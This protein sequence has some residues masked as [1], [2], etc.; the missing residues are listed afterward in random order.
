MSPREGS[1]VKVPDLCSFPSSTFQ[2]NYRVTLTVATGGDGVAVTM[3]PFIG[4]TDG[5]T[6]YPIH[7][8]TNST[9]GGA[10]TYGNKNWAARATIQSLYDEI[11]PVSGELTIK[12]TGVTTS[13]SGV[14][15]AGILDR[16]ETSPTGRVPDYATAEGLA[17]TETCMIKSGGC[18]V[19]WRPQDNH[20]LEYQQSVYV[21]GADPDIIPPALYIVTSGMTVGTTVL[22]ECF[23]NWEGIPVL[24]TVD[25]VGPTPSTA[26]TSWLD[27]AFN[28]AASMRSFVSPLVER[29]PQIAS[30]YASRQVEN[31]LYARNNRRGTMRIEL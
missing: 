20:D 23:V 22:V 29:V 19:L 9:A 15:A 14:I 3:A 30:A 5:L 13:D 24:D 31:Y 10:F 21:G 27:Q 4:T 12:Y 8:G 17:F 2:T 1:G 26:N 7:T 16:S 28:W 11:R 25:L 6:A 18:R